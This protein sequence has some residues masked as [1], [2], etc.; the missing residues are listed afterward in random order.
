MSSRRPSLFTLHG[1]VGTVLDTQVGIRDLGDRRHDGLEILALIPPVEWSGDRDE[2]AL[3]GGSRL[4]VVR[5]ITDHDHL[6]RVDSFLARDALEVEALVFPG[7]A[8]IDGLETVE[9]TEAFEDGLEHPLGVPA[10]NVQ[11][12]PLGQLADTLDGS[13]E[14]HHRLIALVDGFTVALGMQ[15]AEFL[16]RLT[17]KSLLF[18]GLLDDAEAVSDFRADIR[19]EDLTIHIVMTAHLLPGEGLLQFV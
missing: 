3:E 6:V 4:Q 11:H 10:V 5:T 16:Q 19:N 17:R 8:G 13:L 14:R 2:R 12:G 18:A 1:E 7:L 15:V 9:D